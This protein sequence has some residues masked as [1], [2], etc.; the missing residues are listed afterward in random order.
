ML[1]TI[2]ILFPRHFPVCH[3]HQSQAKR[4]NLLAWALQNL[5][6]FPC[7]EVSPSGTLS[8]G[9]TG[10]CIFGLAMYMPLSNYQVS[11]KIVMITVLKFPFP[12]H[13]GTPILVMSL[14]TRPWWAPLLDVRYERM[15]NVVKVFEALLLSK[16]SIPSLLINSQGHSSKNS[17]Y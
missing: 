2:I 3:T 10:Q 13:L 14:S 12:G 6:F 15:P 17:D 9:P 5:V 4:V 1:Q 8:D 16:P 7:H 11:Q